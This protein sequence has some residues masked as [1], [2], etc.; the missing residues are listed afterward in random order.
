V[1]A[2]K[3]AAELKSGAD[4]QALAS[5]YAEA[6]GDEN[7]KDY[8]TDDSLTLYKD[9]GYSEITGEISDEKFVKWVIDENT[10][11]GDIYVVETKDVGYTAILME[12]PVHKAPDVLTYDVR[13]ILVKFPE[14]AEKAE[15]TEEKE[16]VK[17]ELLDTSAYDVT[18]DIAANTE[19]ITN[20]E[21]YAKAQDILKEYLD[22]DKTEDAF[23]DLAVKYS[24]DGN[25]AD[26]GI[27]EDVT[28]GYMV[29]EFESWA[30]KEGREYGD[31]G[32]VETQFGYHIMYFIGS[33]KTT[34]SDTIRR[35]LA[36]EEYAA[37]AEE[38]E[39]GENVKITGQAED[40]LMGVEEFVV[41]LAKQQIRNIKA[42]AGHSADDGHDHG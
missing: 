35:A 38:L 21:L 3:F 14:E 19:K 34:W 40:A 17:V 29:A 6:A 5:K 2:D 23:A 7:F 20:T 18:V 12:E 39:S 41:S 30:L 11:A 8:K 33:E 22:G 10:K 9:A 4:F 36:D 15:E 27:Y 13:H 31:V 16:E 1:Q 24:E 25:A 32:I 26:G 28:E 37:L 42:N